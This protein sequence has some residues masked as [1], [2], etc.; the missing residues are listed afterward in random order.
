MK[1]FIEIAEERKHFA[2]LENIAELRR[3]INSRDVVNKIENHM[4]RFEGV[5]NSVDDIKNQ[6]LTNDLVA[7]LFCKDP[8]KQNITEKLVAELLNIDKMPVSGKNCV[9]FNSDG[10]IV[11]AN[12][13]GVS[14]SADFYFN[15]YYITQKYTREEGGAQDNQRNDVIDFL[16][17]GSKKYKVGALVDG[18]Y[19]N[20]HRDELKDKFKDNNNI[21][22]LS[23]D[24]ILNGEYI[25]NA[26]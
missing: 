18:E 7:S 9:R 14:K 19:W 17:K 12:N 1:T 3:T 25:I 2:R 11:H 21:I 16:E 13:A 10:D 5:F 26:N 20:K 15:D 22:I 4:L 6:I 24:E 8:S 23:M